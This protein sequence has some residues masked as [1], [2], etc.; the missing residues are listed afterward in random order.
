MKKT[1]AKPSASKS[2]VSF[3]QAKKKMVGQLL[4]LSL[5]GA[6]LESVA[7]FLAT[8][9]DRSPL[10]MVVWDAQRRLQQQVWRKHLEAML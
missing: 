10:R 9:R 1:K 4:D 8:G 6:I 7:E 2:Q 5:A 3:E